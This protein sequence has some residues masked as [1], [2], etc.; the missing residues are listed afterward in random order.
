MAEAAQENAGGY[1]LDSAPADSQWLGQTEETE[2]KPGTLAQGV[3]YD[4][5]PQVVPLAD[6][7]TLMVF[8]N[9]TEDKDNPVGIYYTRKV[10][11][12]WTTPKRISTDGTI[13]MSP[14]LTKTENGASLIWTKLK[15]R[16]GDMSGTYTE[17]QIADALYDKMTVCQ[18]YY[19][20]A[21]D[22]WTTQEIASN[23]KLVSKP[24]W[25]GNGESGL[26]VWVENA[27]G[28]ETATVEKPDTLHFVYRKGEVVSG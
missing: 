28:A 27:A 9:Y 6:G 12:S 13:E 10:D 3:Y 20:P 21:T 18:A 15:E 22:V 14:K 25:A 23:G 4:V 26:S 17:E 1:V 2:G 5:Q 7:T 8:V 24:V 11:G 19:D 16:L